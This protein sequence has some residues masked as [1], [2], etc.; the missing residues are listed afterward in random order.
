M[1]PPGNELPCRG[2]GD[3]DRFRTVRGQRDGDGNLPA[4]EV[5]FRLLCGRAQGR[6]V[7][8]TCDPF[9]SSATRANESGGSEKPSRS[10][11]KQNRSSLKSPSR[12]AATVQDSSAASANRRFISSRFGIAV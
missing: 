5:C 10:D 3:D 9:R 12:T 7:R 8:A 1:S 6:R 2:V 4:S 11:Y